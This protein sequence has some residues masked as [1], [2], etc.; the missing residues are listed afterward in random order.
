MAYSVYINRHDTCI[1]SMFLHS[2][3]IIFVEVRTLIEHN[4]S[5]VIT[6]QRNIVCWILEHFIN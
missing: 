5:V 2:V 6:R 3:N 4:V 1:V